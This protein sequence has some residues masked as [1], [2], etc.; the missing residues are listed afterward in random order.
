MTD[1]GRP[2]LAW[3]VGTT[4]LMDAGAVKDAR[5]MRRL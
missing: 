5:I 1:R 2:A 4:D 3:A